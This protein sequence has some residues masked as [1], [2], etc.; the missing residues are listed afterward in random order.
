MSTFIL[1][2]EMG[3]LASRNLSPK[4]DIYFSLVTHLSL[5]GDGDVTLI[6]RRFRVGSLY[7]RRALFCRGLDCSDREF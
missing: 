1:V 5:G 4:R 7:R 6:A 3:A 2:L